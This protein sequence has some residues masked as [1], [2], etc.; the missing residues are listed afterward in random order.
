MSS[1]SFSNCQGTGKLIH[2]GHAND[3]FVI[4]RGINL[5]ELIFNQ[6]PHQDQ[7]VRK[8]YFEFDH[9]QKWKVSD[10]QNKK[11]DCIICSKQKYT[12]IFY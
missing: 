12:L 1:G 6:D 8:R 7:N 3:H 11:T 4:Y 2:K 5:P 10:N 9:F